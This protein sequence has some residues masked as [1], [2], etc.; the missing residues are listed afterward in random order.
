MRLGDPECD[1]LIRVHLYHDGELAPDEARQVEAHVRGC[2]ACTAELAK[3]REISAVFAG[4]AAGNE[5][6]LGDAA[7]SRIEAKLVAGG[8]IYPVLRLARVIT[9]MAA[10]VLLA[11]SLLLWQQQAKA[12]TASSSAQSQGVRVVAIKDIDASPASTHPTEIQ[13]AQWIVRNL[14]AEQP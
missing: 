12:N 5:P 1:Q 10:C 8:R 13:L 3:L 9:A 11:A 4:A 2:P 14:E 7:M 6:I